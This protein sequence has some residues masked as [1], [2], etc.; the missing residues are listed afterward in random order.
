MR[1]WWEE[2]KKYRRKSVFVQVYT[3]KQI[4]EALRKAR[5]NN[6]LIDN[7]YVDD[8]VIGVMYRG[9]G[10]VNFKRQKITGVYKC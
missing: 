6:G 7:E 8:Y 2:E 5:G 4:K 1:W 3:R 10:V 9:V